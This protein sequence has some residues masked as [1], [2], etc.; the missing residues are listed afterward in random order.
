MVTVTDPSVS[1][2]L[3]SWVDTVMVAVPEAPIDT[4]LAPRLAEVT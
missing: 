2:V 3:S 4:F 1:S